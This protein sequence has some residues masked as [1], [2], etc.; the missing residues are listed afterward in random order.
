MCKAVD[1]D[2]R[3]I[4][5]EESRRKRQRI[6]SN[7][8]LESLPRI[9]LRGRSTRFT[10]RGTTIRTSR[11]VLVSLA[12]LGTRSGRPRTG[13][14][15]GR[16]RT[17]N[18]DI[19]VLR[20]RNAIDVDLVC[21]R[22]YARLG[23]N[24][25]SFFPIRGCWAVISGVYVHRDGVGESYRLR[26]GHSCPHCRGF[27]FLSACRSSL[28]SRRLPDHRCA[29]RRLRRTSRQLLGFPIRISSHRNIIT[30]RSVQRTM[31]PI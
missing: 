9:R 7:E 21:L 12:T 6:I 3:G 26:T 29:F 22:L 31:W 5:A 16:R 23:Q 14:C 27:C 13:R 4:I 15:R 25:E 8:D 20:V 11:T 10:S 28:L 30:I 2:G 1:G 18:V 24:T 17:N 19:I